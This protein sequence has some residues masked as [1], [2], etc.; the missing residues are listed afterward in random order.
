MSKDKFILLFLGLTMIVFVGLLI[1][2]LVIKEYC[3]RY[4]I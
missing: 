1:S 3:L 4:F 2:M